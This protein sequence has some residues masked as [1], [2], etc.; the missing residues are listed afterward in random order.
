MDICEQQIFDILKQGFSKAPIL[1]IWN[2]DRLTILETDAS[3]LAV[4]GC[5]SQIDS[6]G[7]L[8]PIAYYSKKLTPTESNYDIHDK[9]LLAINRYLNEWRSESVGLRQ[10]FVIL[11]DHNNLEY[12]MTSKKIAER[13]VRWAQVL[14]QFNFRHQFRAG[15]KSVRPDALSGRPQ[16]LH[17]GAADPRL[18]GRDFQFLKNE[19]SALNPVFNNN[20]E[21]KN[22]Q[23][24]KVV[25]DGASLLYD[26]DI[27]NLWNTAIKEDS[28]LK[29]IYSAFWKNERSFPT[30]LNLIVSLSECQLDFGYAFFSGTDFGSLIL[31]H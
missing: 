26:T 7:C 3:G 8:H 22:T 16:D 25:P 27:A 20:I 15:N 13:Q 18:Q 9:E 10:E 24:I 6:K 29:E 19:W 21:H 31:N 5:L 30:T 28:T 12:F 17:I 2:E 1:A 14:S 4:G 23:S 11:T